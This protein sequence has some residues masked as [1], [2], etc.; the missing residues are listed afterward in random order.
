MRQKNKKYGMFIGKFLPPH[1]GHVDKIL[2][3][4]KLCDYLFVVVADSVTRSK[5]LCT[6]SQIPF[7]HP[8]TRLKWLKEIFKDNKKIKVKFLNQGM[9]EAYPENIVNWK[10][11]LLKAV[12]FKNC[13]WFVDEKFLEIS[14][15]TF[16]EIS[17]VGFDRTK[18]DISSSQ[19][20]KNPKLYKKY[21]I[22]S[23]KQFI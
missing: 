3:C 21:L 6:E 10:K 23:A 15:K 7:I 13:T 14:K 2:E 17:F 20:R 16:P 19:I 11:K 18:I 1:I 12:N 9:L 22:N 4:A 8:K 5:K